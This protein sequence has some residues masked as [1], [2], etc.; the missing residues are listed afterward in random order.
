M[1]LPKVMLL[2]PNHT[3]GVQVRPAIFTGQE[4][5]QGFQPASFYKFRHCC[6][7]RRRS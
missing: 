7:S 3:A 2:T 1:L 5:L 6:C 4:G